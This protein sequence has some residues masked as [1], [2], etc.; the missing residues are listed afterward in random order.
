MRIVTLLPLFAIATA[1]ASVGR[2]EEYELY[3]AFRYG[4]GPEATVAAG[5]EYLLLYPGGAHANE[6]NATLEGADERYWENHRRSPEQLTTYLETFPNGHHAREARLQLSSERLLAQVP[7]ADIA[8]TSVTGETTFLPTPV[9]P[10]PRARSTPGGHVFADETLADARDGVVVDST[11]E[12]ID[13]E[14]I[15][16]G[17]TGPHHRSDQWACRTRCFM[18][19]PPGEYRIVGRSAAGSV[20]RNVTINGPSVF[21]VRPVTSGLT[22]VF[23]VIAGGALVITGGIGLGV[24]ATSYAPESGAWTAL[25]AVAALTGIGGFVAGAIL[26]GRLDGRITEQ[27]RFARRAA[28]RHG[29]RVVSAGV[30]PVEGG[31]VAGVG[32]AF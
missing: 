19:L 13:V 4:R 31:G 16:F 15:R 18:H 22:P 23:V 21:R 10:D 28:P 30:A 5:S 9:T 27:E 6:I 25:S 17:R 26:A 12:P 8:T 20:G 3:R 2:S 24:S 7:A 1:C 14:F 29:W 32:L 11:A